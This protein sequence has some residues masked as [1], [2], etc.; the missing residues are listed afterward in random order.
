MASEIN[1]PEVSEVY[2]AWKYK[3]GPLANEKGHP[4]AWEQLLGQGILEGAGG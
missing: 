4:Y 3:V 1:D 2:K